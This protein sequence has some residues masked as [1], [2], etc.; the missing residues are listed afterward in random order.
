MKRILILLLVIVGFV[1]AEQITKED[2]AGKN[3]RMEWWREARFGLFI[4][5]GLYTIPAG[6]WNGNTGYGEWIRH[7]AEIPIDVYDK[8]VGQFN[9]V[10][11]NA[12]EWV[13]MAKDAG[14]KYIVITSKH[15]D[16]FCLFNSRYTDFDILSTPFK[17]DVLKELADACRKQNMKMCFYHSIMDW[18]HPDYLPRRP[19]EKNRPTEG[20]DFN[21]FVTYLKNQI[22]ELLT[23]Y[24]DIGVLWF[25]GEWEDTWTQKLGD[26]LYKY[27]RGLDPRIIINNRISKGR[28]G[29]EGMTEEGGGAGDFGTPEQQIPATG[30]PGVDW[31]TC[32][33]M[34][35]HWGYNKA[36]NNW[37]SSKDLI[38][39]LTDVASKGGNYLLNVGPTAEGLFPQP[40]IDR[41]REIGEWMKLNGEAIY[42]TSA[43]PFKKLDWGRCTQKQ[44]KKD[45]RLYLHVFDWPNDSTLEIPGLLNKPIKAYLLDDANKTPIPFEVNDG[46]VI[47]KVA[48]KA[49]NEINS[50]IVLD[51][52]GKSQVGNAPEIISESD[53]FTNDLAIIIKS[54]ADKVDVRYT[55]D[56]SLPTKDSPVALGKIILKDNAV[57][58][59]RCFKKGKA[60]SDTTQ[61]IFKKVE[62]IPSEKIDNLTKGINYKFYEGQF[63]EIPG[64]DSLKVV[65][66]GVIDNFTLIK[67]FTKDY[68]ALDYSGYINIPSD[69]VYT[70]YTDS[71]DGSLLYIGDKIVVDNNSLH[72]SIEKHG[73]IALAKGFHKIRVSYFERSGEESLSVYFKAPCKNK[74]I[75]NSSLLFKK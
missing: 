56:G 43:S 33:T 53:I 27:V 71:D 17:R 36:N 41:L 7:N 59:T 10:K 60:I 23:N 73:R 64:F 75:L 68:F 66:E 72:G 65:H 61:R 31:E 3:K 45:T 22:K 9:P 5:W 8:F 51:I 70:F 25:D 62:L 1:S 67:T 55:L 48:D 49:P 13:K 14:M 54:S 18:H 63:S 69:G 46:S 35:D 57:I 44:I 24:G 11:F 47:L 15:H 21:Q 50:V 29:M 74:E 39:I 58:S 37:K 12:D 2:K 38:R 32:M 19:W 28:A 6:E 40:S 20:A 34:N 52:K 30:F 16:G 26:D 4:H 42:G